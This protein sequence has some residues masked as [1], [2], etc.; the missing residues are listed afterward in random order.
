MKKIYLIIGAILLMVT[1]SVYGC[2]SVTTIIQQP[3]TTVTNII[4]QSRALSFQC[5]QVNLY[6]FEVGILIKTVQ[7]TF[8]AEAALLVAAPR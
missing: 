4:T 2:T 3:T 8:L 1:L 5:H 6:P 7:G